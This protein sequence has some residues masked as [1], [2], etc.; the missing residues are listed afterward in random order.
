MLDTL[1]DAQRLLE[2]RY[3]DAGWVSWR[4]AEL[5][6]L[7]SEARQALL[8]TADA[9]GRLRSLEPQL[10]PLLAALAGES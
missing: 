7:D 4:I 6:P 8:E 9:A 5:L 10:A 2:P 1:G 3:D